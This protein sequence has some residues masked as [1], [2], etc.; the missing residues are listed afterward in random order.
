MQFPVGYCTISY[1]KMAHSDGELAVARAAARNNIIVTLSS[2]STYS[3]EEVGR[4]AP[5]SPK[6]FQ[7]YVYKD[8]EVTRRLVER[9]EKAGYRAI[10]VT[11]DTPK[12]GRREADVHNKFALPEHLSFAN[13]VEWLEEDRKKTK[14]VD[15]W[16][17]GITSLPILLK[18]VVTGKDAELAVLSGVA[19]IIVS[20]HGARQLDGSLATIDCL[21]EVAQAVQ[22]KIPVLMDSG[23][24]R[25]TDI[26]KAIA[27]G[28]QAVCIGRAVL[29][30]LAVKGEEGVH[31][32]INL[33]RD[34]FEL[35]LGLLG[36]RSVD[37]IRREMV[38]RVGW[39]TELPKPK[40]PISPE[41][42]PVPEY[43]SR[44]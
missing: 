32:V 19:G 43:P 28:A 13:F 11:V 30:G 4:V 39:I 31:H 27:L 35:A 5:Q 38:T 14:K 44:M 16:L 2:L 6:W 42:F 17:K 40:R 25:G 34:E 3:I 37:D 23:V 20:N 10:V 7:L 12:L 18:G 36:C 9:A 26:V 8:R 33:Y 1:A 41:S 29:W 22:G 21:E 15:A 24:R